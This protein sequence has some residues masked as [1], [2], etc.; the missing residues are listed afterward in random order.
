M[1]KWKAGSAPVAVVMITLN[2]AHH[3]EAILK[4]LEGWAEEVFIVDSYSKDSTVDI[5]LKYG[6]HVVQRKFDDFG[7]Q[8]NYA[9]NSMPISAP[10][11]MKMDPDER[12][13]DELK[14]EIL[15]VIARDEKVGLEFNIRLWFMNRKL[16]V[17]LRLLR[18]WPTGACKFS[19]VSVNEHPLVNLPILPT[20]AE[21][22]H[23]DSPNLEHWYNKQNGYTTAE[24]IAAIDQ[25]EL[26]FEPKLFGSAMERRMWL[27]A[28]FF[29]LPFRYFIL[30][31][32]NWLW[33]GAWR[34][35]SVGYMWSRLRSDVMR[36]I[37]YK[38]KEIE[39]TGRR[40]DKLYYGIGQSHPEA[41]Q[42]EPEE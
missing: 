13:S 39:L 14:D 18:L 28:K 7:K 31:L 9:L 4:N 20:T 25:A 36:M 23:H 15:D 3:M 35:G 33:V 41:I 12:M 19:D 32:Y 30:F 10:W 42:A 11:T 40:P 38:R 29:K 16:P 27:K 24:A 37:E 6:A 2:E 22:E 26:S 1:K 5:A 17:I 34:A 8:W 21:L